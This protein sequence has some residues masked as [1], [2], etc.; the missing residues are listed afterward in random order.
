MDHGVTHGVQETNSYLYL[1]EI[2]KSPLKADHKHHLQNMQCMYS[3]VS[4]RHMS[5]L[6]PVGTFT[7]NDKVPLSKYSS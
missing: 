4:L 7:Y 1:N 6:M 5:K 2:V 3:H